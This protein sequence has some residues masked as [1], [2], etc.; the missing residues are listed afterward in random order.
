MFFSSF[1]GNLMKVLFIC[2]GNVG[3]SQ[4]AEGIFNKLANGKATAFSAGADPGSYEGNRLKDVGPLVVRC[5]SELGIDVSEK[6]SK[7]ITKE[8]VNDADM[9]ISMVSMDMLPEYLNG[10]KKLVLWK[11]EDPKNMD[12]EGHVQI[13]NQIFDNVSKLVEDIVK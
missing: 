12:Y 2:K 6:V 1:N 4:M 7:Q 13:R 9:V 3:R 8:M 11:I 10:S 5:M